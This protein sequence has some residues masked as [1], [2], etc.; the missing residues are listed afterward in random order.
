MGQ[1][2]V[3]SLDIKTTHANLACYG[4]KGI[5]FIDFRLASNSP[6]SRCSIYQTSEAFFRVFNSIYKIEFRIDPSTSCL[7]SYNLIN[8]AMEAKYP[9]T[10]QCLENIYTF[11]KQ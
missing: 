3:I 2:H 6:F 10:T 8:S 5:E 1:Y 4:P 7:Q 9:N 11:G